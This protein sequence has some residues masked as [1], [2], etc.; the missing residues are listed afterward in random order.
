MSVGYEKD[1]RQKAGLLL[2]ECWDGLDENKSLSSD[3]RTHT[4]IQVI[5][6]D[7]IFFVVLFFSMFYLLPVFLLLICVFAEIE[8]RVFDD[9]DAC[10]ALFCSIKV[11]LPILLFY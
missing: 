6:S 7:Y 11:F 2:H 8:G 9:D 4:S 3:A 10:D 1:E 5:Q